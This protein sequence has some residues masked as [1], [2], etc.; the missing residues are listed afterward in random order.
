MSSN[1][2]KHRRRSLSRRATL[3]GA[4][5]SVIATCTMSDISDGGA[6]VLLDPSVRLPETFSLWLRANG[7]VYRECKVAWRAEDVL[8]V[9]FQRVPDARS[10]SYLQP[11]VRFTG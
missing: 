4:D 7:S 5:G 10:T 2:R 8:G 6:R 1:K 9:E 11:G 3:R